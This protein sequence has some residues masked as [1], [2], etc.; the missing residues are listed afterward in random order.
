MVLSIAPDTVARTTA[1][2]GS[3]ILKI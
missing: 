3:T 1:N 2:N